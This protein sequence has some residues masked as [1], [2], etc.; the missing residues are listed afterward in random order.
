MLSTLMDWGVDC[1]Q[2][3]N[4]GEFPLIYLAAADEEDL[5]QLL[6]EVRENT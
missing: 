4:A 2:Q 1:N 5:V 3:N 6:L